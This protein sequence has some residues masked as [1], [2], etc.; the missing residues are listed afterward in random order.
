MNS[1]ENILELVNITKAFPGVLANDGIS[2]DVKYGEIHALLGENGA[3]KSTLMSIL[4]GLY[5][6]DSGYIVYKGEQVQI[7]SPR[8]ATNLRIGMVHQHFKLV[9]SF[10]VLENIVLGDE[11]VNKGF[12]DMQKAR[13][14]VLELSEEYQFYIQPDELVD[15]ITVGM[16][17][18][19]EILKMLYRQCELLIFDEP[20]AVLIPQE[21]A[22]LMA[23]MK[24]LAASGKSIIFITHKLNEI[25][26]A[27]NRCTVLRKGK[28]VATVQVSSTSEA[29]LSEMMVGRKISRHV[30]KGELEAK[31]AVLSVSGL[32][33]AGSAKGEKAKVDNVSFEVRRNEVVC[34]VGVDGNGQGE[35]VRAICGLI[36]PTSGK[37]LLFGQD[38]TST[39]VR[40]RTAFGISH[41]PEDRQREG[42]VLGYSLSENL[43]LETY[44]R[45]PFQNRGFLSPSAIAGNAA[46]LIEEYDIRAGKGAQTIMASMSGGNQQKAII[47][48]ELDLD[49]ELL[50]AVQPTRGLDVGAIEYIHQNI[51]K[52]RNEGKAV[53]LVT[54][55]LD[56]AFELSDRLLVAF[57]GK[58][59]GSFKTGDISAA[60]LGLYMSGAKNNQKDVS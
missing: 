36:K 4:F 46:R 17:Q 19:V 31:E 6:P 45:Y 18:R 44:Y 1:Q 49:P 13:Q 47:A 22:Q 15:N 41:V 38:I 23:I 29:A 20:T 52:Q 28:A 8:Q 54:L 53:L 24:R 32:T 58:I 11:I 12:L 10:T 16:Q 26:E 27:A 60:E 42:L 39:S 2:F 30:K 9:G 25:K 34:I 48:R 55:E 57:E 7:K 43:I 5:E 51:I 37:V 3:G 14:K 35:I 59:T 40:S 21:I 56:E 33:I 50:V